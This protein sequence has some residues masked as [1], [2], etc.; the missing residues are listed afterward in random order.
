M[1]QKIDLAKYI[2]L[3]KYG[4]AYIDMDTKSMKRLDDSFFQ[5]YDLIVSKLPDT[6]TFRCF[7]ALGGNSI[8]S[9]TINN[10]AIIASVENKVILETI[11]EAEKN[12]HS[13]YKKISKSL[14]VY[15][16]T[17]PLC[18]TNATYTHISKNPYHRIK[19]VNNTYFEGCDVYEIEDNRCKIPENAIGIHLY[20]NSWITSNENSIKKLFGFLIKYLKYV[21]IFIVLIIVSLI[22]VY[23]KSSR[24]SIKSKN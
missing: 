7:L 10:G 9:E 3:Y 8:F 22:V 19:I 17:G 15:I 5:N 1:I 18:L 23:Y 13:I 16:S 11:Y 24:N 12:R 14:Y 2:I 21:M 4:G 20:E 6:F